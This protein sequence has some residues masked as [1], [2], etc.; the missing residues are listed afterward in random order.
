MFEN[1]DF[2]DGKIVY[3]EFNISLNVEFDK[4]TDKLLEDLLQIKY[5]N[6]IIIDVGWYPEYD[7]NGSFSIQV[8]KDYNWDEPILLKK[9]RSIEGMLSNLQ[10]GID[11]VHVLYKKQ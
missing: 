6:D 4:Q 9:S 11:M 2:Y 5:D 7:A 8:I 10:K 1:I 3:N